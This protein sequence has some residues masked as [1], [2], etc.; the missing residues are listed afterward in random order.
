MS[1]GVA[2]ETFKLIAG[3]ALHQLGD[4]VFPVVS[5]ALKWSLA[6]ASDPCLLSS[7]EG[8]WRL[9]KYG[10]ERQR[11]TSRRAMMT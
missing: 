9:L 5:A 10:I 1:E 3:G 6:F 4:V 2:L 8:L 7:G 11:S